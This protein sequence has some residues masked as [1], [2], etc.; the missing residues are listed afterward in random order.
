MCPEQDC[1]LAIAGSLRG[2]SNPESYHTPAAASSSKYLSSLSLSFSRPHHSPCCP[3]E[4]ALNRVKCKSKFGSSGVFQ[5]TPE[6]SR[7]FRLIPHPARVQ[8]ATSNTRGG[9]SGLS[10][11]D[12]QNFVCWRDSWPLRKRWRKKLTQDN[13]ICH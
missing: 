8:D 4:F 7:S 2:F 6:A 12:S 1:C 5:G 9:N 10:H 11:C 13:N 3:N